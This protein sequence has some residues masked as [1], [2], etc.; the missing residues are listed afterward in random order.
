MRIRSFLPGIA[1]AVALCGTSCSGITAF[2]TGNKSVKKATLAPDEGTMVASNTAPVN[3]PVSLKSPL[4][5]VTAQPIVASTKPKVEPQVAEVT[6]K[7]TVAK[8]VQPAA[9]KQEPKPAPQVIAK[10]TTPKVTPT[11]LPT[12]AKSKH[13]TVPSSG[14]VRTTAYTHLEKD[15]LPYGK[16][17][18]AGS[19]LKYGRIR[20]AAADWSVY[21][22][23]T[24]FK[25]EG[26]PN[27]YEIDDYGSALVGS[28]T[29]DIYKPSMAA[30]N[31]WGVRHV[32]IKVVRWGCFEKS[33]EILEPREYKAEHVRK[34]ARSIRNKGL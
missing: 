24:L 23:G 27:L 26:D 16:K 6:R 4:R 5:T 15:S 18:A 3:R 8:P 21:P 2:L 12:P 14:V 19:T 34:M 22:V 7:Q 25:M 32:P 33:L 9:N 11:P 17:N 1:L 20:S 13:I 29:I 30:M 31:H 10:S 28:K